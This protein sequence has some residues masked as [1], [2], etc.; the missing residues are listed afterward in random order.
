MGSKR[1]TVLLENKG[2]GITESF[3]VCHAERLLRMR[4]N[5][6]W[7]LPSGSEYELTDNGIEHRGHT[8]RSTRAT[9]ARDDK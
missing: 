6:G 2:L 5:G 4:N 8:A 1:T 7:Q 9:R 3:E